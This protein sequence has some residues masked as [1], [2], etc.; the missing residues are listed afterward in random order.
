MGACLPLPCDCVLCLRESGREI[1]LCKDCEASLPWLKNPCAF[2]G[3][4]IPQ[5]ICVKCMRQK[6]A[7]ERCQ[8]LFD[9]TW[10][11]R[12]FIQQWKYGS[13]LH[14]A[15]LF[16]TLMAKRLD[17]SHP[18][19]CI[20]PLPLHPLRQR[21]RGFNQS[22]ELASRISY[23]TDLP[24]NR[25]SCTKKMAT[26]SQSSLRQFARTQ[27]VSANAFAVD[28]T[29]KAKHVL[30]IDDVVTTASTVS[31]FATALKHAGVKTVEIWS[32]CRTHQ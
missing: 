7:F 2:C 25:W 18:I 8:A 31:A 32:V 28:K 6:P 12:E 24:L 15:K 10:P 23:L 5:G 13:Q 1:A 19:D 27:N 26:A 14:F 22:I 30:V 20:I 16:G 17:F 4:M 11:V 3:L 29:F 9:Y 21:E